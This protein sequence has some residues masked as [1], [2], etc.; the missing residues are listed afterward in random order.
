MSGTEKDI[1]IIQDNISVLRTRMSGTQ[2]QLDI[3]IEQLTATV[4]GHDAESTYRELCRA[5]GGPD[6]HARAMFCRNI[7]SKPHFERELTKKHLFGVGESALPGTHGKVAYVRNDR[8]DEAFLAFSKRI[9][10]AKAH[11]CHGFAEACEAVFDNVC[12]FG[13]LPVANDKDGRLYSF[14]AMMDRYELRICDVLDI[15]DEDTSQKTCFALVAR[16]VEL[17]SNKDAR[18]RFEFS[19]ACDGEKLPVEIIS[20]VDTLGGMVCHIGTQPVSYDDTG[21]KYYFAV[22]LGCFDALCIAFYLSM[23]YPRYTPLGLY[24]IKI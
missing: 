2:E 14:Y 22:D 23:E 15:D 1:R 3:C 7:A 4:S 17:P 9:Q 18:C 20:A 21:N 13:I 24:Q 5:Y 6:G 16:K 8:N 12:E 10:R 19:V 11:Y